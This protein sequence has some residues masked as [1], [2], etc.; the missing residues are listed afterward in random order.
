MHFKDENTRM[1][2]KDVGCNGNEGSLIDCRH[3]RITD[4][5]NACTPDHAAGVQCPAREWIISEVMPIL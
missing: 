4:A 1:L 3:T 2:L 5:E